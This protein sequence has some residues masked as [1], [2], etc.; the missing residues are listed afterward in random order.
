MCGRYSLA[1]RARDLVEV[2]GLNAV[3]PSAPDR[4]RYNI[5]PGQTVA[6]ISAAGPS[7]WLGGA[8]WGL[9][10]A[11][12][13]SRPLI[14][15]RAESLRDGA[16]PLARYLRNRRCAA[17][18]DGFFEWQPGGRHRRPWH[19]R[20]RD[21]RPFLMA[22]VWTDSPDPPGRRVAI[23]TTE[24][25]AVVA[26]IHRRMPV[27]LPPALVDAWLDAAVRLDDLSLCWLAPSPAEAWVA[28]PVSPLVN[29]PDRDDPDCVRPIPA[30][31]ELF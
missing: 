27:V 21:G 2:F 14:N 4:P 8:I 30:P 15:L 6:V 31:G 22:A 26:P 7:R 5:A 10:A 3:D 16:F 9:P 20:R 23:L 11:G 19:I 25:N 17:P 1:L 12:G 29:R 13:G 24:P 28:V 18:A